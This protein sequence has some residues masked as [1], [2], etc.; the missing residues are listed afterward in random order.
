[1]K[2]TIWITWVAAA[3]LCVATVSAQA[4]AP[5][6]PSGLVL[7][8]VV[9][10]LSDKPVPEAVVTIGTNKVKADAEGRFVF[11]DLAKGY[12]SIDVAKPGYLDG[13][14]GRQ[15]PAGPA[16]MLALGTDER[17]GNLRI[18][19]FRLAAISGQVL[20]EAGQ[21]VVGAEVQVLAKT[22][23]GGRLV[24]VRGDSI[25][26]DD[27]GAYRI[28]GLGA[29]EFVVAVT[30]QS[31]PIVRSDGNFTYPVHY[32]PGG[33]S[34]EQ[35]TAVGVKVGEDHSGIDIS[36]GLSPASRVSGIIRSPNGPLAA[37]VVLAT[38]GEGLGAGVDLEVAEK[39]SEPSGGFMFLAVPAGS[40]AAKSLV[41]PSAIRAENSLAP[42]R[43][44]WAST[45]VI[46]SGADLSNV[47]V[48][49]RPGFRIS[50]RLVFE[51][52]SGSRGPGYDVVRRLTAAIDSLEVDTRT[53][54]EAAALSFDGSGFFSSTELPPGRYFIRLDNPPA[55]WT[56]KAITFRGR[57][58]SNAPVRLDSDVGG[59]TI[60]LTDR[61][62]DLGGFVRGAAGPIEGSTVLVFPRDRATWIDFGRK[63][64][65]LRA[66]RSSRDGSFHFVGLPPGDYYL[67]AVDDAAATDWQ[68]SKRLEALAPPA[69]QVTLAAGE[70]R[71]LDIRPTVIR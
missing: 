48:Q 4:P 49:L 65:G 23:L 53:L 42:A 29:G 8:V 70:Q 13:A 58:I 2:G 14:Y 55:G 16:A 19:L 60:T 56:L 52:S 5:Q 54:G 21:P 59:L 12:Y 36:L 27:R 50:G 22:W 57:D 62:T 71:S 66:I 38:S 63:P 64:L 31:M 41:R 40:Y 32:F 26:S 37:V 51:T 7:G 17:I 39:T 61:P 67:I 1:M 34:I 9:D 30:F 24:L 15:R 6:Q 28:G 35:A 25:L 44:M 18:A 68:Q 33:T 69:T 43:L 20:D 47:E 45:P 10:S 11:T 46:V 3:G